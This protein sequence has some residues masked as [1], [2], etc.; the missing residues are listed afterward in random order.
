MMRSAALLVLSCLVLVSGEARAAGQGDW[1]A[2]LYT[3]EG[4]ELR[5]DERIFT[6]FAIF[7]ALGFDEGPVTRT[8]PVARVSYSPVRQLVRG[9]VIGGDADVR[10]AA[11]AYFDTH[12]ASF[13]HYLSWAVQADAPPFAAAVKGKDFGDLKGFEQVM[14][15]AWTGWKLGE[16]MA[17]VQPEYR[18]ALKRYLEGVDA[19]LQKLRGLLKVPEGAEV[20]LLV[21]LLDAQDQVRSARGDR[22]EYFLIAGPSDKPNVEG[23]LQAFAGLV[24]EPT[25]AK[26]VGRWGGGAGL[27]RE[28]QLAGAPE[29]TV[30]EYAT[31][32]VSLAAA[33]KAMGASDAA[34]DDAA[35]R[36]YFGIKDVARMFDD[37]RPLDAWVLDALQ[38]AEARR[39]AKK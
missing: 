34:M 31:A 8:Q 25:V 5:N 28:A 22:G 4:V 12:Q 20:L 2:S 1:F 14:A 19:P 10:K 3:G 26:H 16:V 13:G 23:L 35:K 11:D 15:K 33:M 32:L 7:N 9:K 30:G 27:L 39:P 38:K 17:Q 21:N 29:K 24:F 37:G 6:L 36:G 18:Q